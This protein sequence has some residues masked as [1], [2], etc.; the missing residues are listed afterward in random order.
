LYMFYRFFESIYMTP[1]FW[2]VSYGC[3]VSYEHPHGN[4]VA[5]N[6]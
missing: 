5:R 3:F 6:Y 1:N 4:T 2:L